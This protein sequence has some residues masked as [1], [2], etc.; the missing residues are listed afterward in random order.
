[1]NGGGFDC[2]AAGGIP[3]F[4]SRNSV[5]R[6][7]LSMKLAR[8]SGTNAPRIGERLVARLSHGDDLDSS[9]I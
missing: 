9:S 4:L 7:S 8:A 6:T 5:M 3:G 2:G 1:M